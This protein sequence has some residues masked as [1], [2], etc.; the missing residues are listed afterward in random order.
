MEPQT[1]ARPS[2]RRFRRGALRLGA[3]FGHGI[4]LLTAA[5]C[6]GTVDEPNGAGGT[7]GAAAKNS[8]SASEGGNGGGGAG[9][10]AA[11]DCNDDPTPC[12]ECCD[13]ATSACMQFV[14]HANP[15]AFENYFA[16]VELPDACGSLPDDCACLAPICGSPSCSTYA[17]GT[18]A[19]TCNQ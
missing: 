4:A 2:D 16:C 18:V 7:G 9:G 19:L 12:G 14:A 8:S 3:A 1:R 6:G 17:D 13:P 5:S 10:S 11:R 15:P